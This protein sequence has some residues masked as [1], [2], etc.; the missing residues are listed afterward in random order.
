MQSGTTLTRGPLPPGVY[1][2]RRL[3]LLVV[4]AVLVFVIAQLLGGGSD[5]KGGAP[6]AQQAAAGFSTS[7]DSPSTSSTGT[8]MAGPSYSAP[9]GRSTSASPLTLAAP[10]GPCAPSDITVTPSV[11]HAVAGSDITINLALE[12]K[13]S[14]ACTW[15]VDQHDIAVKIARHGKV[16]WTSQQCPGALPVR[17]VVVRNVVPSIVTMVW[18]GRVSTV[19]CR[20]GSDFVRP[21]K[22]YLYAS[23][24]GG[25]PA[26]SAFTLVLPD[27][28]TVT[29]TPT[30]TATATSS[31]SPSK[32]TSTTSPKTR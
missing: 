24:L 15:D 2:R 19:G 22:L 12:T 30:Q 6:V 5:G 26:H 16:L 27:A 23:T 20:S 17:S 25:E 7:T 28:Q 4:G 14:A 3:V 21:G 10:S 9:T 18:N 8:V 13:S 11:S 29:A 32:A 31:S 1:W